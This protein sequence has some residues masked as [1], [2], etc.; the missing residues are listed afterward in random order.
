MTISLYDFI[1]MT[2]PLLT[3]ASCRRILSATDGVEWRE[4]EQLEGYPL[5]TCTTFPISAA[6]VGDYPSVNLDRVREVDAT[7]LAAT[8]Q[9]LSLYREK[10]PLVTRTDSGFD[11]LRY[12]PGQQIAQ[13]VD[14]LLPRVLAMSI[15]LNDDYTGGE[16]Q[17]WD[18]EPFKLLSGCALMFPANFMFPHQ[19][20][21]ITSGTRYAMITWFT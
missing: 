12:E 20:L 7:L 8:L 3:P 4:P 13:H 17:F 14:D 10:H 18:D 9:A 15:G 2:E 19:V 16:F 5:R 1:M 11:I 21:P 6:V